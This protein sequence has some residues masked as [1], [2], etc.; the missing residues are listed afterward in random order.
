VKVAFFR[1]LLKRLIVEL[2]RIA[3]GEGCLFDKSFIWKKNCCWH[4]AISIWHFCSCIFFLLLSTVA[5]ASFS[6]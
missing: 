6:S 1:M 4:L 2:F 3:V 5:L